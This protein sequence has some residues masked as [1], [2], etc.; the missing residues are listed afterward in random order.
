VV[1]A[2][3][4]F[5]K[6][7]KWYIGGGSPTA[8]KRGDWWVG[9][10]GVGHQKQIT[11]QRR[12]GGRFRRDWFEGPASYSPLGGFSWHRGG[13]RW[14]VHSGPDWDAASNDLQW[15]VTRLKGGLASD[16]NL[17]SRTLTVFRPRRATSGGKSGW[18]W[19]GLNIVP[20]PL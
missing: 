7:L 16:Q 13:K 8:G 12:G 4:R 19:G 9:C 15:V 6:E 1:V 5:L 17:M 11:N 2:Q 20:R 14:S 18:G 10:P 3:G